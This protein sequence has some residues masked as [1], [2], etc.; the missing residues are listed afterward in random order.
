MPRFAADVPVAVIAAIL[1]VT[2]LELFDYLAE[3]GHPVDT[4]GTP[5][6]GGRSPTGRR[7]R[8]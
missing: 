2:S 7:S 5:T 4:A 6:C 8:R 1:S 3:L